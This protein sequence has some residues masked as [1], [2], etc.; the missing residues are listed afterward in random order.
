MDPL[1]KSGWKDPGSR[2]GKSTKR[3][4]WKPDDAVYKIEFVAY[5]F[6]LSVA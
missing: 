2:S 4:R 5:R 1:P 6:P 3:K